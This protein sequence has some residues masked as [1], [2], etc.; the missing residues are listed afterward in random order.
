MKDKSKIEATLAP[1][2]GAEA[3][4]LKTA[5]NTCLRAMESADGPM[6]PA[7]LDFAAAMIRT[8]IEYLESRVPPE[9]PVADI[10]IKHSKG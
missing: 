2:L 8:Y 7:K 6:S 10:S 1:G 9:G 4:M 5:T 3:L